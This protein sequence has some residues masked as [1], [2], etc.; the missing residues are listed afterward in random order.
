M[1]RS[2]EIV[3]VDERELKAL[4]ATIRMLRKEIGLSQEALAD[5]A[6]LDR[7]H[8]GRIERGE[9]N[10]A[11]VN[12]LKIRRALGISGAQLMAVAGL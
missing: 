2:R 1:Q 10:L 8:M 3:E 4:G 7:S 9:R 6:G 11:V 12:L 5:L